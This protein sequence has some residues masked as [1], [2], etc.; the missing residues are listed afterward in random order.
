MAKVDPFAFHVVLSKSKPGYLRERPDLVLLLVPRSMPIF[1]FIRVRG[2]VG[3]KC[4]FWMG[5][6]DTGL[7]SKIERCSYGGR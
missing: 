6:Q 7:W 3:V 4:R 2:W 1:L 5:S